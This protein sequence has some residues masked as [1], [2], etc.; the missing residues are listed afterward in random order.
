M[1]KILPLLTLI[2]ICFSGLAQQ[3]KIS[4]SIADT[5]GMKSLYRSTVML[6]KTKDS[7]LASFT[8]TNEKGYFSIDNL[9]ADTFK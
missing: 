4:G 6:I 1:K 5:N 9:A 2:I 3:G 7:T 8:Y